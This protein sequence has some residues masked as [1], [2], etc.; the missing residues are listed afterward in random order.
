MTTPDFESFIAIFAWLGGACL[1]GLAPLGFAAILFFSARKRG[2]TG[3]AVAAAKKT[4]IVAFRSGMGL[5]RLQGQIAPHATP[6]D[7]APENALVYVRLKVEVY[8]VGDE[9]S[10]WKGLTTKVRSIPFQLN[11]GTGAVWVNP[12]GLDH[13]LL[14][15]GITPN[16]EQIETAC[17]LLGVSRGILR[18]QLRFTLWELRAGQTVTVVGQPT[19]GQNGLEF[20]KAKGQTFIVSPL[21]GQAVDGRISTQTKTSQVWTYILGIP[22]L[23]FLLCGLG[24]AVVSLIRVLTAQ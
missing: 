11:D 22:G 13:Q 9:S 18:G 2:Q 1:C 4:T 6:I 5:A 17:T 20:I 14:D 16:D 12:E 24:G 15:T 3:S 8:E 23:L 21:L 7:G 10:G 19:Q